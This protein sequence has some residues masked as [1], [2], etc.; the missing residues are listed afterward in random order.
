MCD[1]YNP[2]L[3]FYPKAEDLVV[4]TSR[5]PSTAPSHCAGTT[6]SPNLHSITPWNPLPRTV[7]SV[8]PLAG[9]AAGYTDMTLTVCRY[10]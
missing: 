7:T 4:H 9:V 10:V 3:V 2:A 8:P 1:W 5:K 6:N